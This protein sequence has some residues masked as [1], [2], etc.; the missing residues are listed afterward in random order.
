MKP[1]WR[2]WTCIQ[3]SKIKQIH[4]PQSYSRTNRKYLSNQFR[5]SSKVKSL[6]TGPHLFTIILGKRDKK[7]TV[8]LIL[9]KNPGFSLWNSPRETGTQQSIW[10]F[11]PRSWIIVNYLF[12]ILK[13]CSSF[14]LS[15]MWKAPNRTVQSNIY[16]GLTF[17]I[18][19]SKRHLPPPQTVSSDIEFQGS[20]PTYL[21]AKPQL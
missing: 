5:A 19:L 2:L 12:C 15:Q 11:H 6:K 7:C 1:K 17:L 9:N 10:S 16:Q 18:A 4:I 20:E 21:E 8:F 3:H 14:L 13:G